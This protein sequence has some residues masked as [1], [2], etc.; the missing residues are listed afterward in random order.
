[1]LLLVM[2]SNLAWASCDTAIISAL[3]D[4]ELLIPL[5]SRT[6]GSFA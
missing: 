3:I 1:M 6:L 4:A 2:T 5:V